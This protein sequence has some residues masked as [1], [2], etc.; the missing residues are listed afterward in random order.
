[1]SDISQRKRE[2]LY[3][4]V[5]DF[6]VSAEPVG[7]LQ[8][9]RKKMIHLSPATIRTVMA[10]L[11]ERGYLVRPHSSSGRVPTNQA[12]RFYVDELMRLRPLTADEKD[13]IRQR[14]HAGATDLGEVLKEACRLISAKASQPGLSM[15]PP[16]HARSLK[17]IQFIRLRDRLVLVILVSATGIVE[18]KI[19][20][21]G[22]GYT[23][24]ELDRMHN[25]LN[26][27]LAGMTI[28][29]VRQQILLE[30]KKAQSLY[31]Q[32]LTQALILGERVFSDM[33]PDVHIEGQ[34][35]LCSDPEFADLEK[36]Q[37]ILRALEEKTAII[38]A[39]DQSLASPGVKIF[40]GEEIQCPEI[41][42]L[43]LV[44]SAYS[45]SEGNRGLLG[46]IGPTRLDYARII[47]LVEFTSK[48]VTDVLHENQR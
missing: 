44:T 40:I 43:T 20:E 7:S 6:I 16:T 28:A 41:N 31:D 30:M 39:L 46:V 21:M 10:E 48:I 19:L 24:T 33:P 23:Q 15:V 36:M 9:A 32:L 13:Q 37:L 35:H 18:N 3:A 11:E 25:Y 14:V 45:D 42:G 8:I 29:K 47:P 34:S 38:K 17:H 12:Y 5:H 1:M 4:V 27:R 2:V 26:D 22:H